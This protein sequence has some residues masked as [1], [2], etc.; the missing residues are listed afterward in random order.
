MAVIS[1]RKASRLEGKR[2][3]Y[4]YIFA[5][6][7]VLGLLIFYFYPLLSSIFYSFTD[8]NGI[9]MQKFVGLSNYQE[10][11]KDE[12][13]WISVRNTLFYTVLVVP[14]GLIFGVS[15]A[16]LLNMKTKVQ[17]IYRVVAFIPTLVPA[18]ASAIIW[19]WLLNSQFGLVNYVLYEIGFQN[20]PAW[21]GS[22]TWAKPAMAIIAQWSLGTTVLT[23][24]A[25]LQDVPVQYYEAATID[26]AGTFTRFRYITLPLLTPVIFFNLIMSM[27]GAFQQFVLPMMISPTGQ[28]ANMMMFYAMYLYRNAFSYLKMGFANSM[29]WIMFII[30]M[31]FTL[32]VYTT[33][34]KWVYY[35]GDD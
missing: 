8:F 13:F 18:V 15:V 20:P 30:V 7:W 28:P 34:S 22:A 2:A 21:F 17:G 31:A 32:I 5:L 29:A 14:V 9:K 11:F 6:P 33:S 26:G 3:K 25:G 1:N 23:Y 12:V 19:Q 4:G 24:L 10:L 27:I 35:M 16:L